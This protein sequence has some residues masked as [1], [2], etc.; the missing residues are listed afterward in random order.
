[1]PYA[2]RTIVINRPIDEVFTFLVTPTNDSRWRPGVKEISGRGA[3]AVGGRIH[4]VVHGPGGR[5]I[6]ADI[7]ITAYDPPGRYAFRGIAGPVRPVG[8][9]RL[10][11]AG[12]ATEVTFTLTADLAGIKKLFM[13]RAVQQ[14]MNAEVGA[15]ETAKRLLEGT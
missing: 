6:P 7:E 15:L 1:M 4:Q 12:A 5:G 2:H 13:S 9:Y 8:E 14:S 11:A 3:P 10:A